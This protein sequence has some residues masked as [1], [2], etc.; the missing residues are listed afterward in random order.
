M[1]YWGG[2]SIILLEA[3]PMSMLPQKNR[4]S[5]IE[6]EAIFE[7]KYMHVICQGLTSCETQVQINVIIQMAGSNFLVFYSN[8]FS[9]CN[10]GVN[11]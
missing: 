10:T 6:S 7:S 3:K 11:K 5:E 4:C 1:D 2:Q 9:Y 8:T